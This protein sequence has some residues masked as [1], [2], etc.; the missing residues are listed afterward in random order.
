MSNNPVLENR[1]IKKHIVK[2][3]F[4][5]LIWGM[6]FCLILILFNFAMLN[7]LIVPLVRNADYLDGKYN[8]VIVSN[9][10]YA[11]YCS[12]YQFPELITVSNA[13]NQRINTN[14]YMPTNNTNNLMLNCALKTDEIAISEKVANK[15]HL[16]VGSRVYLDFSI[17]EQPKEFIVVSIIPY[18]WNYYDV[19]DNSDFSVVHIGYDENLVQR[20]SLKSVYYLSDAEYIDYVDKDYSY[21]DHYDVNGEIKSI[22]SRI[23]IL[24]GSCILV[25]SII[26]LGFLVFLSHRTKSE[27]VKYHYNGYEASFVKKIHKTD[28]LFLYVIPICIFGICISVMSALIHSVTA[29]FLTIVLIDLVMAAITYFKEIKA[30]GKAN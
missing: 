24:I 17:S 18:C 29:I 26:S 12:E 22:R 9:E 14:V 8:Q 6:L 30:Y 16:S 19:L 21:S 3:V 23:N 20:S 2:A 15:L 27:A 7:Y 10:L 25:S 5:I 11:E 4:P 28:Y 13:S 1:E